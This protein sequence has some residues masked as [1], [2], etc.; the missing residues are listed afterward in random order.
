MSSTWLKKAIAVVGALVIVAAVAIWWLIPPKALEFAGGKHVALDAYRGEN[1]SGVPAE[2]RSDDLITRGKYLA[3]AADCEVC[4]TASGGTPFAGGRAFRTPFGVLYSP[5]ITADPETGI[6]TW[7]DED[8]LRAVHEGIAKDGSRLYPAFP[9]ESYTLMTDEDAL[10]IKAYLFSL[11]AVRARS[12]ENEMR[13][14]YNQRWLMSFWSAFYNPKERFRP[15]TE[16]SDQWNRG[17]YLAEALAHCG[18]CHTPRN[19]AQA[20]DNRRKF[21]GA[22][23]AGWQ[24]YDITSHE[25][26]LGSWNDED[27]F[28]YLRNGHANGRGSASGP[29]REVVNVSTSAL[30]PG[31]VRALMAYV[32]SVPGKETARAVKIK[33]SPAPEFPPERPSV[34]ESAGEH[35]FAGACA[36][37]HGWSGVSP[38]NDLATITGA[39]AVNDPSGVNAAQIVIAGSGSSSAEASMSM[40]AFG[41][42]YSDA[43]LAAVVNYVTRRFGAT[44]SNLDARAVAEL[45]KLTSD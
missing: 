28:N 37:C 44:P 26:G 34:A 43:E 20:P 4:H 21:A 8:F 14:P 16:R 31:D 38:L 25:S 10:A 11:P 17:A 22:L 15:R 40:P 18:D 39:R 1:P 6:G 3:A 41:A 29:M 12:P 19:I 2:L 42:S 13:F 24:A 7:S 33:S 45:R 27:V 35:L 36:G 23:T 5:N 30:T 9:Y 32:R